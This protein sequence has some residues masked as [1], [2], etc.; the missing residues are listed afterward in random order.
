MEEK[1]VISVKEYRDLIE[2]SVRIEIFADF[3]NAQKYSIDRE[4]CGKFLG[5]KITCAED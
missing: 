4:D 5:F 2:K 3:V 1:I